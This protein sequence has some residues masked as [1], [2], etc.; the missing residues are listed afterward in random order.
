MLSLKQLTMLDYQP[1]S[2]NGGRYLYDSTKS[3]SVKPVKI[4][5]LKELKSEL[6]CRKKSLQD[7]YDT[8]GTENIDEMSA[9]RVLRI[10]KLKEAIFNLNCSI[11]NIERFLR[12]NNSPIDRWGR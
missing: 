8:A 11:S 7:E 5:L 1:G 3:V 10:R 6:A 9:E 4:A 12:D 2:G